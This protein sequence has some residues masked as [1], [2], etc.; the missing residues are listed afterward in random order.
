[1]KFS[2]SVS[3]VILALASFCTVVQPT[4]VMADSTYKLRVS[5][6]PLM[7]NP[8]VTTVDFGTVPVGTSQQATTTFTNPTSAPMV[9]SASTF[10]TSGSAQLVSTNCPAVL[11]EGSSCSLVVGLSATDVG[12][13]SGTIEIATGAAAGPDSVVLVAVGEPALP[14][15]VS[16]PL[17]YNFGNGGVNMGAGPAQ[18]LTVTN[19]GNASADIMGV[20]SPSASFS[21]DSTGCELVLA[22]G[23]SCTV[24]VA[25]SARSLG[26]VTANLRINLF[27]GTRINSTA[28][29]GTGVQGIPTWIVAPTFQFYGLTQGVESPVRTVT[30][31]NTGKGDMKIVSLLV[32]GDS[33]FTLKGNTCPSVL[34]AGATC[35]VSITARVMD[36]AV[37]SAN[38][39]LTSTQS[40]PTVTKVAL[41]ARADY[42]QAYLSP[43]S[44]AFDLVPL[45]QTVTET[46]T[47]TNYGTA[48][49]DILSL[50][51]SSL[52]SV[53]T[54]C[55]TTVAAKASCLVNV[56]YTATDL[57]GAT[58][59][60]VLHT[61]A[62]LSPDATVP[63]TATV[64]DS[65][66]FDVSISALNFGGVN[67]GSSAQL[68]LAVLNTGSDPLTLSSL[69]TT[70]LG[71]TANHN[72]NTIASGDTCQVTV[73]FAPG[74]AGPKP[75]MLTLGDGVTQRT[76][77][78]TGTGL[79][80]ALTVSPSNLAFGQVVTGKTATQTLAVVNSGSLPA[81]FG[82]SVTSAYAITGGTCSAVLAAGAN[83]TV[84][85]TFSPLAVQQY[86]ATLT[87]SGSFDGTK[88][89]G[90]TGEGIAPASK[91]GFS[92]NPLSL[93]F[94]TVGL[95]TPTSL[96][97][98]VTNTGEVALTTSALSLVGSAYTGSSAC[99]TTLAIGAS[100]TV[101]VTFTPT[102]IA[103]YPGTL[104]IG[105]AGVPSQTVALSGAGG[106]PGIRYE[107][108]S[109][110]TIATLAFPATSVGS[111]SAT[112]TVVVRN[113]GG[114][115]LVFN[116]TAATAG[117]PFKVVSTTCVSAI[118]AA[119]STCTVAL[120]FTP[121]AGMAYSDAL[122]VQ[123]N[124]TGSPTLPLTG[125]GTVV[126]TRLGALQLTCPATAYLSSTAS[127]TLTVT[128]TG[129]APLAVVAL[130]ILATQGSSH[131]ALTA[132]V[133]TCSAAGVT[134]ANIP[135]GQ[136]CSVTLPFT[137]ATLSDLVITAN[138]TSSTATTPLA[139][140]VATIVA[141]GPTLSLVTM[142]HPAT[143]VGYPSTATHTLT[144]TGGG[145]VKMLSILTG[146][147]AITVNSTACATLAAGASCVLTTTCNPLAAG[148]LAAT[149]TVN[150]IPTVTASGPVACGA[151][152]ASGSTGYEPGVTSTA[153]GYTAS[154][155]WVH[156]VNTGVGPLTLK[157]FMA[158]TGWAL[159]PK[160]A[161]PGQ[162]A[163][164]TA[165]AVGGSCLVLE[166]LNSTQAP[167]VTVSGT[168][169]IPTT[170][171]DLTWDSSPITTKGLAL[172]V[173]PGF[174][175][176]QAGDNKTAVYNVTNE[177]PV[178]ST[179][180]TF[181]VTGAG[182]SVVSNTCPATLAT[183][184]TC[185]VT[186]RYVAGQLPLTFAGVLSATT[187]YD[188]L[189]SGVRQGGTAVS[190]IEGSIA[191]GFVLAAS[192]VTLT[193][194]TNTPISLGQSVD[195]TSVLRNDGIGSVT[196]T[197]M[198]TIVS[199]QHTVT[200]GTCV[201]GA[202]VAPG[203]SC[204]V[205]SKFTPSTAVMTGVTL[206]VPTSV[207][208]KSAVITGQVIPTTDVS[209]TLTG[210]V[211]VLTGATSAYALKVA[212]G[213]M[214]PAKVRMSLSGVNASSNAFLS[215]VTGGLCGTTTLDASGTVLTQGGGTAPVANGPTCT[216][217][218]SGGHLEI[219]LP[220]NSSYA[221]TLVYNTGSVAGSLT[222]TAAAGISGVNDTNSTN[223]S[224]AVTTAVVAPAADLAVTITSSPT[225][226]G[227]NAIGT[228]T[229]VVTNSSIGAFAAPGANATVSI[230]PQSLT[231][232]ATINPTIL[233]CSVIG[234]GASCGSGGQM[235]IPA[236]GRVS[237]TLPYMTG[238]SA[239]T[240][241][242]TASVVLTTP[243]V[244]E[245]NLD[246]NTSGVTLSP[247][248]LP[249]V[250]RC[251]F[252][253]PQVGRFLGSTSPDG[254]NGWAAISPF[255]ISSVNSNPQWM[256]YLLFDGWAQK[257]AAYQNGGTPYTGMW[258][259][260]LTATWKGTS[261]A[262]P[263]FRQSTGG[264]QL[265]TRAY[266]PQ[267]E[268]WTGSTWATHYTSLVNGVP[269]IATLAYSAYAGSSNGPGS[270]Y[271]PVGSNPNTVNPLGRGYTYVWKPQSDSQPWI[272]YR[273]EGAGSDGTRYRQV[274]IETSLG[275][276][277]AASGT[278]LATY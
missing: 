63:L 80:A 98:Q 121:P 105:F 97:V 135:A 25:F 228:F 250:K 197:G 122:A 100:C 226:I 202:M 26:T 243:G 209:V 55:G 242:A 182:L 47:L 24:A 216:A 129:T 82:A 270:G 274:W 102:A 269:V 192:N 184:A 138:A 215:Q 159:G 245:P 67:V 9:V 165:L 179:A 92:V 125:S 144:N 139:P 246:N 84:V 225:N 166:A 81:A 153:G 203:Q 106:A 120:S 140:A 117:T 12:A 103:P 104:T 71:Y 221:A 263:Y 176:M 86:P 177:A 162:C 164:N 169:R 132:S 11:A 193:A 78:L 256:D 183:G 241:S 62:S 1:M 42:S 57:N 119:N 247:V 49:F 259:N 131:P 8:T 134:F 28:L 174:S 213:A 32:Q 52:F 255:A 37:H 113:T 230:V 133:A 211:Q 69:S 74:S 143:Q 276:G 253:S 156:V 58:G 127:C 262:A 89:V 206:T 268:Y 46:L 198:P 232:G 85:V 112:Q 161:A 72:C 180:I 227:T 75:G 265:D 126:T 91:P 31:Q 14:V 272:N 30:L 51:T 236:G 64:L 181:A 200:G 168:Q 194:G 29:S 273:S 219:S 79:A 141:T 150:G 229:I 3:R 40:S 172:T 239:G 88:S 18:T 142:N 223:N 248:E 76:V 73:T 44:V 187:G 261:K 118:I 163:V 260:P 277:C 6:D 2:K 185:Q 195:I 108:T 22:P 188:A 53:T 224:A 148:T 205:I 56:S 90:V 147:A 149:L 95:S 93:D 252:A 15:L 87:L 145:A 43:S 275:T 23:D 66:T 155:N 199:S 17:S 186:V 266:V 19:N 167:G 217:V 33:V 204:T 235:Y 267:V 13:I 128:S 39:I 5:I 115:S 130:P 116:S 4:L 136:S 48:S 175:N 152:I 254:N 60:L 70:G 45:G 173:A 201:T 123:T 38:I 61:N 237:L 210:V 68:S 271:A 240:A 99:P 21:V 83:C 234:T 170:A 208:S 196:V 10:N 77:T 171:G 218:F 233:A 114:T 124:V 154:G 231:G 151:S 109:G 16:N 96:A 257:S 244:N 27:D 94:H 137:M 249:T 207:G 278:T 111:T 59:T 238:S 110:A 222:V 190:K 36:L 212:N 65:N 258:L 7:V 264:Y 191:I 251:M 50:V 54:D 160:G 107:N 178:P 158:A 34:A 146:I 20:V 101:T 220:A 35:T 214:G 41:N 189:N 157:G